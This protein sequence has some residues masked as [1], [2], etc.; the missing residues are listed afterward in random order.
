LTSNDNKN[1]LLK[2]IIKLHRLFVYIDKKMGD[3]V[4]NTCHGQSLTVYRKW[5]AGFHSTSAN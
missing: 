2:Q 3:F 5:H 4:R 1:K